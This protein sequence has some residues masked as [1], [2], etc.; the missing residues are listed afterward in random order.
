MATVADLKEVIFQAALVL[1]VLNFVIK[2]F[3]KTVNTFDAL[4]VFLAL[5]EALAPVFRDIS[6]RSSISATGEN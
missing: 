3:A 2:C 5:C 4:V 6:F 1:L